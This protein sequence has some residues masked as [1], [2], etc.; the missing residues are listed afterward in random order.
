MWAA[1]VGIVR[2]PQP[3]RPQ[4]D[5]ISQSELQGARIYKA[6]RQFLI[7]IVV[8]SLIDEGL[9]SRIV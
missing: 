6:I 4:D 1:N 9:A 2:S 3:G 7:C 5:V 8:G